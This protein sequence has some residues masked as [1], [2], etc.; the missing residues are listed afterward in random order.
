MNRLSKDCLDAAKC[1]R[2][3]NTFPTGQSILIDAASEIQ[4]LTEENIKQ[5][6]CIKS[7]IEE[8]SKSVKLISKKFKYNEPMNATFLKGQVLEAMNL[9]RGRTESRTKL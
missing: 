6:E 9:S 4:R 5:A 3:T 7:L 8:P 1:L 2:D